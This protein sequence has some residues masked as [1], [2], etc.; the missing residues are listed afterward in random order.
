M[1]GLLLLFFFL[2]YLSY[3]FLSVL[4]TVVGLVILFYFSLLYALGSTLSFDWI[5]V[6][7]LVS[8]GVAFAYVGFIV[9][10]I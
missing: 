2:Y 5:L 8:Y 4:V 10:V 3:G 7:L 6:V 9:F 1:V